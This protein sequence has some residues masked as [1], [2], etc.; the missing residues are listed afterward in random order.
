M[1]RRFKGVTHEILQVFR[2][3]PCCADTH[4]DLA[5]VKLFGLHLRERLHVDGVFRVVLRI[6]F[7]RFQ[8][9]TD[10]A[11][12]ILVRRF[13]FVCYGI[14]EDNPRQFLLDLVN[15]FPGQLRHIA[16][17]NPRLFRQRHRKGLG[18]RVN[19]CD[20][21]RFL[22]RAFREHIRFSNKLP[23]LVRLFKGA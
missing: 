22:D 12:Q 17:V 9:V 10:I 8:L 14:L 20:N 5:C 11:A 19:A 2:F 7:R 15:A 16:K 21:L 13:P 4:L 18:C 6:G 1:L 3:Y 23:F